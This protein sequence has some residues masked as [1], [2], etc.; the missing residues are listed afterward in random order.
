MGG[1]RSRNSKYTN[2]SLEEFA[3]KGNKVGLGGE[4]E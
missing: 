2:N 3:K 4:M 1:S